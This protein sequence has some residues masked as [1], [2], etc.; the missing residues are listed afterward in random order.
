M[1]SVEG[2]YGAAQ[3][4]WERVQRTGEVFDLAEECGSRFLLVTTVRLRGTQQ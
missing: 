2:W 1:N 4:A 3:A